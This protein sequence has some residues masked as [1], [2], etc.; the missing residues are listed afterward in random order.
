MFVVS[1]RAKWNAIFALSWPKLPV[2]AHAPR[3]ELKVV[4]SYDFEEPKPS[5]WLA[6]GGFVEGSCCALPDA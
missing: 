4:S 1:L 5:R 2:L 3:L 6:D